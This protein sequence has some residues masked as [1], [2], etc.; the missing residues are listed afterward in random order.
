MTEAKTGETDEPRS[1]ATATNAHETRPK[2]Q[3]HSVSSLEVGFTMVML[4]YGEAG[5]PIG[6]ILA[7][8]DNGDV[9]RITGAD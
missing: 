8:G 6:I 1:N 7:C 5:C 3:S 4:P 2:T 9:G